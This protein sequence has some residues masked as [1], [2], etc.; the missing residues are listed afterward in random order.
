MRPADGHL[1]ADVFCVCRSAGHVRGHARQTFTTGRGVNDLRGLDP[2]RIRQMNIGRAA[3]LP[4]LRVEMRPG[5]RFLNSLWPQPAT[6][7]D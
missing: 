4:L 7:R 2:L 1:I 3:L 5:F 6:S